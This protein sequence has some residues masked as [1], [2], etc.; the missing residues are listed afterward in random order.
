MKLKTILH[1][2]FSGTVIATVYPIV[3]VKILDLTK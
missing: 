2:L 1:V 3:V